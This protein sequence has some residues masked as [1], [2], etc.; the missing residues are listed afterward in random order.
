M[1]TAMFPIMKTTDNMVTDTVLIITKFV[2]TYKF[3][4][5]QKCILSI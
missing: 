1:I 2:T 5:S 4:P 3:V